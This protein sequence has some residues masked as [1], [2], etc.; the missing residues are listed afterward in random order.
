MK[1]PVCKVPLIA[2]ERNRI[3]L[4]WCMSCRGL[5]F[6]A[7]EIELLAKML[8]IPLD[9]SAV[10]GNQCA[11]SEKPRSCP[12]CA[13]SMIK[14]EVPTPSRIVVDRCPAGEGIWFDA[15]ELGAYIDY[16]IQQ[17]GAAV[18]MA[19]FLGETFGRRS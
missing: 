2:V 19:A 10:T 14:C 1:C 9:V 12:R 7:G 18:P 16:C 6:D 3:E 8:Q 17:Q 4:D 13:K 15:H 5:W 11:S